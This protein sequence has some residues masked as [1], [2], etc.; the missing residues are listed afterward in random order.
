[1]A[2]VQQLLLIVVI[3]KFSTGYVVYQQ[4]LGYVPLMSLNPYALAQR[5]D[6]INKLNQIFSC[7]ICF[8][9]HDEKDEDIENK[10]G[11]MMFAPVT[12]EFSVLNVIPLPTTEKTMMDDAD[13]LQRSNQIIKEFLDQSKTVKKEKAEVASNSNSSVILE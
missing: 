5:N 1:M 9:D 8:E 3:L 11:E 4:E 12:E 10:V 7:P 6:L 13:E 2:K